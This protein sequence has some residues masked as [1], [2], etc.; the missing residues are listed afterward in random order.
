MN[1]LLIGIDSACTDILD[2]LF[3]DGD[4]PNLHRVFE[5]GVSGDLES[6]I[7]PWTA[8]AWPSIYTGVNPGKHGVY[9]FL[10]FNGYD[11]KVVNRTY[12]QRP[13]IWQLLDYYNLSSVIVNVPV[14]HPPSMIDG[15]IL[16]GYVAPEDPDCHPDGV[17]E[18]V[19]DA[20]GGYRIYAPQS[21]PD[22]ELVEWYSK[23][24]KMRSKAF[25]YLVNQFQPDFG[26][27]Q[28]QQ[29]DT[30][31]HE[32]P[33][34]REIVRAIYQTVDAEVGTILDEVEPE[35]VFVVSDHGMGKYNHYKF[36]VNEFLRNQ[37][38]VVSTRG[39]KGMPTWV[40][41]RDAQLRKGENPTENQP[42]ILDGLTAFA[43]R[44]GLTTE[45]VGTLLE[46][47][48]IRE[49]VARQVP[50]SSI[51]A[52]MQQVDFPRSRAYLRE[53]HEVGIRINLKGREP[54]GTVPS[55]EYEAV[56]EELIKQ[57]GAVTTPDGDPVFEDVAPREE[58]FHGP[59]TNDAVDIVTVPNGFKYALSGRLT[60]NL[61]KPQNEEW[62][63]K[64]LG[65]IAANGGGISTDVE[66]SDAHIFDVAPTVLATFDLPRAN[67]MDGEVL[68]FV[69]SV[70]VT[71]YPRFDGD[72]IRQT[73]DTSIKQR[74]SD[75]GY[76][77]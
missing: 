46:N 75:I 64:R 24:T 10:T 38:F 60:D 7:P 9:G 18:E 31:F 47:L 11:W 54:E 73:S 13:P 49:L 29:T 61:F 8:S 68:E 25:R 6:Q 20:I 56:R 67:E 26:F 77:E 4:L 62:N 43:A 28:F 57:L 33:G 39:G 55:S 1:T 76:I 41:T 59:A 34:N 45:R 16:P 37:G 52:G 44:A 23:L 5:E 65:V 36:H 27:V 30:V 19:R 14:T 17:L 2:P 63:H 12:V 71:S 21:A 50:R 32:L 58:Y 35:T 66:V 15:A 48:G 70:G 51:R 72:P 3:A 40:T 53:P 69:E 22:D 74:L 42:G